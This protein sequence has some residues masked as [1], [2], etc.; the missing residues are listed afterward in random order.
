M[1][2]K[3]EPLAPKLPGISIANLGAEAAPFLYFDGIATFGHYH[4]AIQLE[5]AANI[6]TPLPDGTTRTDVVITAHL[7]CSPHAA[8]DL[9]A[10][11]DKV[12]LLATP[13][14]EGKAN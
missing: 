2:D 4:G 12:L 3:P 5:L 8:A 11:I 7:R 6:I 13:V 9:R 1:T 14:P 10:T